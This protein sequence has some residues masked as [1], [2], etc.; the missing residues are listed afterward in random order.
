MR[1]GFISESGLS[2]AA[3]STARVLMSIEPGIEVGWGLRRMVI[4]L[5]PRLVSSLAPAVRL[6]Q[7]FQGLQPCLTGADSCGHSVALACCL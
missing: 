2:W 6:F 1:S 5:S 3:S 7:L 4:L